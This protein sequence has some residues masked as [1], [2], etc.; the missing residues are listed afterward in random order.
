MSTPST[1]PLALGFDQFL[2]PAKT[3]LH[4]VGSIGPFIA[5]MSML[6]VTHAQ[7]GDRGRHP[8]AV[9]EIARVVDTTDQAAGT[10]P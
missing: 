4:R 3:S 6:M 2:D 7:A 8:F 1:K 10:N 5:G 9:P